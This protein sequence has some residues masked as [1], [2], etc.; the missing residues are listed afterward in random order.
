MPIIKHQDGR[1]TILDLET[2]IG[3]WAV[4]SGE[5]DPTPEQSEFCETIDRMYF[6]YWQ[7]PDSYIEQYKPMMFHKAIADWCVDRNRFR[8][9]QPQDEIGWKFA[10][11]WGLWHD[12]KKSS[13]VEKYA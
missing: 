4:L 3:V 9:S 13:L 7:A 10:R 1:S 12:G 6:K 11:R 2:A 8:P 5:I